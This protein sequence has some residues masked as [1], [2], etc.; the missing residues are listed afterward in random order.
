MGGFGS[1]RQGGRPTTDSGLVLDVGRLLRQRILRP[2]EARTGTILWTYVGSDQ[3]AG[4]VGYEAHLCN[5]WG[6]LRLHYT[7]TSWGDEKHR[8]D[9]WVSLDTTAQPFG[10]RRWWFVCPRTGQRVAKLYLPAGAL[11]FASRRAYRLG[12]RSQ[13]ETPRD[14]ALARAFKHRQRLGDRNGIGD[15][16]EKPKGMR[17]ATYD[18]AVAKVEAA[19]ATVTAHT[20]ALLQTLD[21]RLRR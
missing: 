5:E 14:R 9:Y 21:R 20:W 6:R 7:T 18:R 12:Y 17:W 15:F 16:I 2:G 4:S 1:G 19:E 3:K 8:S 11:T 10:G 13:R